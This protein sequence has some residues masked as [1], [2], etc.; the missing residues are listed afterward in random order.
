MFREKYCAF[1]HKHST[2]ST[3][4]NFIFSLPAATNF[5]LIS[6]AST[7][8]ESPYASLDNQFTMTMAGELAKEL[9]STQKLPAGA[10]AQTY[11]LNTPDMATVWFPLPQYSS[12]SSIPRACASPS[13][14]S[15]TSLICCASTAAAG[16]H[17][18][19]SLLLTVCRKRQL[20]CS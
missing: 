6:T 19:K 13:S 20:A 2:F 12:R 7:L 15:W 14:L 11:R 8:H 5:G 10:A 4:F 18:S 1:T 9:A 17:R 16:K 3:P